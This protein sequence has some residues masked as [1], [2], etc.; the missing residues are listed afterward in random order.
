MNDEQR[1]RCICNTIENAL[2]CGKKVFGIYPFGRNGMMT[3]RILKERYNIDASLLIDNELC[4]YRSDVCR[5]DQVNT[6]LSTEE[7]ACLVT[8][9]NPNVYDEIT[10]GIHKILPKENIFSIFA[11]P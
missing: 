1:Y 8:I 11:P 9:E 7:T 2:D 5:L 3:K 6:M 4:K 10:N